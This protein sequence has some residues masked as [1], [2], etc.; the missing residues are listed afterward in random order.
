MTYISELG[1][2]ILISCSDEEPPSSHRIQLRLEKLRER[3]ESIDLPLDE[4]LVVTGRNWPEVEAKS[5]AQLRLEKLKARL[6]EHG[7]DRADRPTIPAD[8]EW[9]EVE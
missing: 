3:I 7:A 1:T 6:E 4:H 5:P 9:P 8:R 2:I